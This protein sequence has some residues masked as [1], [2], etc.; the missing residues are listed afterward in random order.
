VLR[1][2]QHVLGDEHAAQDAWQATFLVLARRAGSIAR[3]DSVGSWLHGV[4][5]RVAAKARVSAARRRAHERRGGAMAAG[6]GGAAGEGHWEELHAELGRL[7]ERVR[8][9][10]VL[11]YLEGLTQ[12]QVAAQ[13]RCPLGTVQSRLARGRA[14]LRKRLE[15]RGL[16]LSLGLLTEGLFEAPAPAA[17][18]ATWAEATVRAAMHFTGGRATT[19]SAVTASA[20]LAEEVL[21]AMWLTKLTVVLGIALVAAVVAGGAALRAQR[22]G[23][24]TP[25]AAPQAAT[26]PVADKP[27]PAGPAQPPPPPQALRTVRGLVRDELGDLEVRPG[28]KLAGQ[29]AFADGQVPPRGAVVLV[30]REDAWDTVRAPLGDKGR[31]EV[32]GLPPGPISV[33]VHFPEYRSY[34]PPGCRVSGQNK[35]RDLLNPWRLVGQLDRDITN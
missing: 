22:A 7:P 18:P 28:R 1:V 15:R 30:G 21:Q 25:A 16:V 4:A 20:V 2:C 8:A 24:A 11:C 32:H 17:P 23:E 6:R 3:R 31:F 5:L 27:P 9:P 13:L 33:C 10:L 29:I 14:M 19:A 26:P 35:C 12:E 34:T